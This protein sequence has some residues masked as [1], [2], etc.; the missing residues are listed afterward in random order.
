[1]RKIGRKREHGRIALYG[2]LLAA[3]ALLAPV[4]PA[5]AAGTQYH[6]QGYGTGGVRLPKSRTEKGADTS[7]EA[8]PRKYNSVRRGYITSVKDQGEYGTCT[9]FSVICALEASAIR[10]G[11]IVDGSVANKRNIDLS[12]LQLFYFFY[13]RKTDPLGGTQ[14][15]RI[16]AK[17]NAYY[18]G[19]N[20]AMNGLHL[21]S[22]SGAADEKAAPYEKAG[23]RLSSSLAYSRDAVHVQGMEMAYPDTERSHVKRMIMKYGAATLTLN[24][25]YSNLNQRKN[26]LYCS[27]YEN[28]DHSVAVVGWNDSYSRKNFLKKPPHNGAWLCKNQW[29]T[30]FGKNGYFWVSYYDTTIGYEPSVAFDVEPASNYKYNYQYDG[31]TYCDS[32]STDKSLTAANVYTIQKEPQMIE[33]VGFGTMTGKGRYTVTV[34]QNPKK[35][36]P[37]TGRKVSQKTGKIVS[38]GYQ[39]VRLSSPFRAE[40]GETYS[41]AVKIQ[42]TGVDYNSIMV[43]HSLNIW[44]C[45]ITT[46][47]TPGQSYIRMGKKTRDLARY[48]SLA[49]GGAT[50]RIKMYTNA[51]A[52][53]VPDQGTVLQ[54]GQNR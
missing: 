33:A 30:S 36:K 16:K 18:I 32:V 9:Y 31:G 54:T 6:A 2:L 11:V 5:S 14:G 23:S 49:P 27:S 50:A 10:N 48:K 47:Q 29:G 13:H 53:V 40:P 52:P 43:D 1:M 28:V 46:K 22:W 3:L 24:L 37:F 4:M 44:W 51:A 19:G 7:S 35:G 8:L 41:V 34:Y 12:E 25:D 21:L 15:D 39:T 38:R 42:T 45:R 26:A 20:C 17:G